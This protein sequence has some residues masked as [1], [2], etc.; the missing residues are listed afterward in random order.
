MPTIQG[1]TIQKSDVLKVTSV[2]VVVD[3]SP[4]GGC[5]IINRGGWVL[6]LVTSLWLVC[7]GQPRG[8]NTN[9]KT[10]ICI[11]RGRALWNHAVKKQRNS[12]PSPRCCIVAS[13]KIL[14]KS[15]LTLAI[16]CDWLNRLF[17]VCVFNCCHTRLHLGFSAKLRIWQVPADKMEPQ[18][19]NISWKTPASRPPTTLTRGPTELDYPAKYR[20]IRKRIIS[21]KRIAFKTIRFHLLHKWIG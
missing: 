21:F 16:I 17:N 13:Q 10:G 1:W 18:S 6:G 5:I 3:D 11:G 9:L 7:N 14:P 2:R 8:W 12:K 4:A 20:F 19:G 15:S